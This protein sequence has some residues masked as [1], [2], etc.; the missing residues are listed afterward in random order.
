MDFDLI[1]KFITLSEYDNSR[2]TLDKVIGGNMVLIILIAILIL[3][4][5][6]GLYGLGMKIYGKKK[7]WKAIIPIYGLMQLFRSISLN[8]WFAIACYIKKI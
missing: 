4:T 7:A 1:I 8:P 3:A 6:V 2:P 5:I